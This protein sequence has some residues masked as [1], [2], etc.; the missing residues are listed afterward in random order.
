[1]RPASSSNA[2]PAL[3]RLRV[4]LQ[5]RSQEQPPH[6]L[7]PDAHAHGA[8]IFTQVAVRYLGRTGET[9]TIYCQLLDTGREHFDAPLMSITADLVVLSA[10]S[11]GSTAGSAALRQRGEG[12]PCRARSAVTSPATGTYWGSAITATSRSTAL[13]GATPGAKWWRLAR[14]R[15]DNRRS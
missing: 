8:K 4:R 1:M 13:D 5:L 12:T 3:R 14:D 6:E 2:V 7:S 15:W 10:G 11:L 9:W